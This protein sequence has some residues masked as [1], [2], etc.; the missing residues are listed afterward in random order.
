MVDRIRYIPCNALV[1]EWPTEQDVILASYLFSGIPGNEVPR[2]VD[3]AFECS[4]AGGHFLVHDFMVEDDRTG[5][6]MAAL[7]Q[8]QHMA[9][10]PEARSVTPGWLKG[11]MEEVGFT[12]FREE[13][14][15]PGMT[16]LIHA[17]KPD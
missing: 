4:S 14:M 1:A 9:F 16:R 8:L 5:P 2:L 13:E 11:R 15:I 3:Y 17:R 6:P 10:T 7:W 12:D